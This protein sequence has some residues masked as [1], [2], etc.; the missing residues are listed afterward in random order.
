MSTPILLEWLDR[1]MAEH[2][3]EKVIPPA[4]VV[5]DRLTAETKAELIRRRTEE[6]IQA[7]NIS[8]WAEDEMMKRESKLKEASESLPRELPGSLISEPERHWSA[9]VKDWAA[10][11]AKESDA[12]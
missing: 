11:L 4:D 8:A 12:I 9:V 6:V 2:N 5:Q 7:A 1:K 3:A 10:E